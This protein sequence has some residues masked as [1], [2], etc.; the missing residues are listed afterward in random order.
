MVTT[1]NEKEQILRKYDAQV[2]EHCA[3]KFLHMLPKGMLCA[4]LARFPRFEIL[5][6]ELSDTE[7]LIK[8]LARGSARPAK[9]GFVILNGGKSD[10]QRRVNEKTG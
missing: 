3:E 6:Q 2:L 9:G 4:W 8:Q 7:N 5:A 10:A 1:L